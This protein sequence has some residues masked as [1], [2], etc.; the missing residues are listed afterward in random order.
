[1]K[2]YIKQKVFSIGDSYNIL[3]ENG[4]AV[5]FVKSELFTLAAKLHLNDAAGNELYYIK[6]KITLFLSKYE[7]YQGNSLCA[8]I[9]QK[10]T[11]MKS[12]MMVDSNMGS[13][14]IEGDFLSMNYIIKKNGMLF[15]SLS[16]KFLSWGDSYEL[17]IPNQ[18]DAAFVCAMVIAI[19][20]CLHN[21]NNNSGSASF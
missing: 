13:Y 11:F 20:N 16:K 5:F 19:D 6:K 17:D 3:D 10:M 4:N 21:E 18:T 9:S 15:G 8:V 2:L 12:R 1:M 14:E 7:I